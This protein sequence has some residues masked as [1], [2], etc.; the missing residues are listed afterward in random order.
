VSDFERWINSLGTPVLV[1]P[2]NHDL[3][4]GSIESLIHQ[5]LGVVAQHPNVTIVDG[6]FEL[7]GRDCWSCIGVPLVNLRRWDITVNVDV[8]FLH[9]AI[10]PPNRNFP[11]EYLRSVDLWNLAR[12][13]VFG[14]YHD[15]VPPWNVGSSTF[16]GLGALSRGSLHEHDLTRTPK[17]GILDMD[18]LHLEVRDVPCRPASEVF[19]LREVRQKQR[20]E[21]EHD[22]FVDSLRSVAVSSLTDERL[23]QLVDESGVD[24]TVKRKALEL[25][26]RA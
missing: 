22:R 14:H 2:G 4:G 26:D 13:F 21:I 19:R 8:M 16:V 15:F 20:R 24:D 18:S 12:L 25:L 6:P 9:Q 5:P 1:V 10:T 7:G 23:R 3:H 11:G 17:V